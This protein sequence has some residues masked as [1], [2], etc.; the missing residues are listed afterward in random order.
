MTLKKFSEDPVILE[1]WRMLSTYSLPLLPDPLWPADLIAE[2]V[3]PVEYRSK[4]PT[5][6]KPRKLGLYHTPSISQQR[7]KEPPTSILFITQNN[8]IVKLQ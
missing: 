4:H 2:S 3:G 6:S 7:D 8:Q 1:L 5:S